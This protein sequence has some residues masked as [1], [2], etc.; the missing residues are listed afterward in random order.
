VAAQKSE[1]LRHGDTAFL[2]HPRGLAWLSFAEAWERF[3]YY[4]MATLLSPYMAKQLLQ[5]DHVGNV[6][7]F[8]PVR[9]AIESVLGPL[10]PLALASAIY[11]LYTAIVYLTPIAGGFLADRVFGRTRMVTAGAIL[12]ALGHFLMAFDFSF[13]AALLCLMIGVGCFKGNIAAQVG[14]LYPPG[15][16]RRGDAFQVFLLG[17]QI[18]VIVSPVICSTMSDVFGWH[19]GFGV[20]GVGMLIGLTIYLG[21][22]A[23]LPPEPE[24][25]RTVGA[26]RRRLTGADWRILLVLVALVPV[27][28]IGSAGNQQIP[29]AYQFW[30]GEHMDLVFFGWT[31]PTEWLVSLDAVVSTITMALVVVFWRWW[32]QRHT[33]PNEITKLTLGMFIAAGGPLVLAVASMINAESGEKVSVGWA[34]LFELFNDIGFANIFPIGLALFSRAAPK[35]ME[36]GMLGIY[37]THLFLGNLLVGYLGGLLEKMSATNFW[38]LH[39]ALIFAAGVIFLVVRS[40]AGR[41]LAPTEEE[42]E[43]SPVIATAN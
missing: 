8:S 7:G 31:M 2:G 28:A 9:A 19:W 25:K 11:G 40:T 12:M 21:G 1:A 6:L 39:A 37:Y 17:V 20:A 32:G 29:N 14:D 33:E 23:W 13:L 16:P 36:S 27:L 35:S 41:A 42:G 4:G 30:A 10:S 34:F 26:P 24:R 18:A 43:G 15:D 5:P 3:S 38:L 22:R